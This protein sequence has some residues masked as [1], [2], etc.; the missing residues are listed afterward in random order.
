MIKIL[1]VSLDSLAWDASIKPN[2]FI[3]EIN[4]QAVRDEIDYLF[5]TAEKRVR[6]KI[7]QQGKVKTINIKNNFAD[8]GLTLEEMKT[9]SCGSNCIFC[10]VNQNPKGLRESLYFQDGDYRM[11]FLYGNY[12]TLTNVGESAMKR[13]VEQ[14]LS[15]LYISV[16]STVPDVRKRYMNLRKDDKLLKKMTYLVENGISLHT[17][18]V[19]SPNINDGDSLIKTIDDLY[20][21]NYGIESLAIVPVG[22]TKH[23]KNLP[24]IKPVTT[25]YAKNLI[26]I[27]TPIQKKFKNEPNKNWLYLSDEFYI[28]S[29]TEIPKATYYDNYPQ[30]ENGVGMLRLFFDDFIKSMKRAPKALKSKKRITFLTGTLVY[31]F[32]SENVIPHLNQIKNLETSLIPIKNRM[33]GSSVTVTGLLSGGS[34]LKGVKNIKLGDLVVLPSNVLNYDSIFLDNMTTGEFSAIIKKP[35]FFFDLNWG[36]LFKYVENL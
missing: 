30:I 4:G 26:E 5:F 31:N 23:R 24:K 9:Y 7:L 11:S 19:L 18:I 12:I 17:Q 28:L 8:I 32:M 25:K 35:V 3:V 10:F 36:S 21:L 15:P 16:H 14:K 1:D 34:L 2:D 27:I 20:R 6:L 13:I 33:F 22:L 29:G